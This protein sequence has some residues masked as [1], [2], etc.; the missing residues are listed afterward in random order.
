MG[1]PH[2]ELYKVVLPPKLASASETD[3][4]LDR[5]LAVVAEVGFVVPITQRTGFNESRHLALSG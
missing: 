2:L 5:Q 4:V 1:H 3:G